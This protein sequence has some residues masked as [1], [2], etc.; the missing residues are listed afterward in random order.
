MKEMTMI[1]LTM[2]EK[3]KKTTMLTLNSRMISTQNLLAI[4]P[5]LLKLLARRL[6]LDTKLLLTLMKWILSKSKKVFNC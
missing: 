6:P 4:T 3:K 5:S 1:L 2:K